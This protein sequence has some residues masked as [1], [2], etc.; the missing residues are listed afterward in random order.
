MNS[1]V[2]VRN[3]RGKERTTN[4]SIQILEIPVDMVTLDEVVDLLSRWALSGVPHHVVT[5]NPEFVMIA[6][7]HEKFRDVLCDASLRIPDGIGI[8]WASRLLGTPIKERVAGVDTVHAL[9]RKV[10][11]QGV[12]MFLLGAGPGVAE[13][14]A[15]I[16]Q[17]KYKGLSVSGTYSGSPKSEE[18]EDICERIRIAKPHILLV[19]FG[20]PEQDLW[21]AR[22]SKKL[23]I[24]V[25]MGVGGSFDFIAGV[26][27]RAPLWMQ[28]FGLEWLFRLLQE[29]RR[30]RRML[31]LPRFM[32]AVVRTRNLV[33]IS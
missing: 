27:K 24:P 31:R 18:E 22:T 10:S 33:S 17:E 26:L 16:L 14:T 30:W 28:R 21:I 2:I 9:A 1:E 8:V 15:M 5:V 20:A 7:R 4:G 6:Q 11:T 3:S 32:M 29:P 19:A 23:Q 25:A 13:R 12:R